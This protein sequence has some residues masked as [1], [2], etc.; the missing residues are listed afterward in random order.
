MQLENTSV[1]FA[2]TGSWVAS[3]LEAGLYFKLIVTSWREYLYW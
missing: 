1:K 3:V 2:G